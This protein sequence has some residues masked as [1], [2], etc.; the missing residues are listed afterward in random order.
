MARIVIEY[1]CLMG[2]ALDNR[3]GDQARTAFAHYEVEAIH[4]IASVPKVVDDGLTS[5]L[6]NSKAVSSPSMRP[7]ISSKFSPPALRA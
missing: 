2:S 6:S 3:I 4:L 1:L 5:P 7:S